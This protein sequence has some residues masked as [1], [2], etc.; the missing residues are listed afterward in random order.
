MNAH[1]QQHPID[2]ETHNSGQMAAGSYS[3]TQAA[4]PGWTTNASCSDGSQPNAIALAAE[5][6][7]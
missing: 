4:T 2:D 6:T 1:E 3:V 7:D 5:L